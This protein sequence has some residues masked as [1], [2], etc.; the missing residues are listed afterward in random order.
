MAFVLFQRE[1]R[2]SSATGKIYNKSIGEVILFDVQQYRG[3]HYLDLHVKLF[4]PYSPYS[5]G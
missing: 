3:H 1:L 4:V 5:V 2:I